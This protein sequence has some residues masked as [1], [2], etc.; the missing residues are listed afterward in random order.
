MSEFVDELILS[1]R[2]HSF[3][4]YRRTEQLICSISILTLFVMLIIRKK[5]VKRYLNELISPDYCHWCKLPKTVPVVNFYYWTY[6]FH[7]IFPEYLYSEYFDSYDLRTYGYR[8]CFYQYL[9]AILI[10]IA[11]IGLSFALNSGDDCLNLKRR[12]QRLE[13]QGDM[14]LAG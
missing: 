4:Y 2:W 8:T 11:G 14:A 6:A 5:D 1:V 12:R 9:I 7:I 10:I 3:R 13:L